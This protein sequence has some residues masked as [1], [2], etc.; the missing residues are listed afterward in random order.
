MKKKLLIKDVANMAGVS[1]ATISRFLNGKYQSMSENTREKIVSTIASLGYQPNNIAR[2]LR[3][4]E[5]KTIA[6]IMA[7]IFNPYSMDVLRGIEEYCSQEGYKIF[8]C[9]A[10]N[11]GARER[12]YIEEMVNRGVDGFIL[13]TTG[14]ND[15]FIKGI[16]LEHPVVLIGRK[17]K[18][19]NINSVAADNAQGVT[20]AL[21]HLLNTDCRR[22]TYLT[23]TPGNVSPRIERVES[24][25]HFAA[26]SAYS[27]IA[28]ECITFDVIDREHVITALETLTASSTKN[29]TLITG[30]GLLSLHVVQ[31]AK[32]L[33]KR[34]PEDFSLIGFDETEWSEI[35]KNPLTVVAQP[36]YDIGCTAAKKIITTLRKENESHEAR[37]TLLPFSLIVRETA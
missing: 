19:S 23:P 24:F 10:K 36:T 18:N 32:A 35:L 15:L 7:D 22:V 4:Q 21:E 30:N 5:S 11:S 29:H 17:I 25:E 8:I 27:H 13:N 28:F 16:S 12:N 3:S 31:G 26:L 33:N 14:E 2:S 9:D 37:I 34:I 1:T 20:L 6:V